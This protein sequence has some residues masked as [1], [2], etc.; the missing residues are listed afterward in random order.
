M[1]GAISGSAHLA[2]RDALWST[3]RPG[4]LDATVAL[5]LGKADITLAA[6]D[7]A[8]SGRVVVDQA[9]PYTF[10]AS[11][12]MAG[13]DMATLVSRLDLDA[14]GTRGRVAGTLSASGRL[15]DADSVRG[16]VSLSAFDGTWRELPLRLERP[17]SFDWSNSEVTT[18][19]IS[20]SLADVRV[21]VDGELS[22][23]GEARGVTATMSGRAEQIARILAA[24]EIT[25]PA[26][27]GAVDARLAFT[28]SIGGAIDQRPPRDRGWRADVARPPCD[29]RDRCRR[30]H[31]RRRRDADIGTGPGAGRD[32]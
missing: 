5:A 26:M 2:M 10:E 16:T 13:T 6:P 22:T 28:G 27:E 12:D 32:R 29:P 4:T 9:S 19:N 23:R 31:R 8:L 30:A 21:D 24:L 3:T 18:R 1:L 7:L 14:R 25:A 11:A 17:S 20:I 15:A